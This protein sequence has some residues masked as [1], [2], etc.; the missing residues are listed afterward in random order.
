LDYRRKGVGTMKRIFIC[1]TMICLFLALMATGC[2]KKAA[3]PSEEVTPPQ[4]SAPAGAAPEMKQAEPAPGESAASTVVPTSFDKK[5][6]F[7]FDKFDLQP[8]AI[9]T[10][11]E[12]AVFLKAKPE[13]KVKIEGNCDE[14]GTTEYNLALGERRAKSALDYIMSQGISASR[15]STVS[16]GKEKP[17][18]PGHNDEA[19]AKNRR[20][21]FVFSK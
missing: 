7:G 12:L 3:Q 21:E 5:I 1:S 13:L 10:L 2:A 16:Y 20:D 15:V 6:Y 8:E 18:D 14:R 9:E 17:V 11:N 4:K 19:W